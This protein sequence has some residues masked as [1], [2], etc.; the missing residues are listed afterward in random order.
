MKI[1]VIDYGMGNISSVINAISR[2]GYQSKISN[3][4]N[5]ILSSDAIILPGV[6][7]FKEAMQNLKKLNLVEP[8]T[9][10]ANL[11]KKPLLGIC[12]GMQ[13]LAN[14][15]EERGDT[16][17]LSLIPGN[18]IKIPT[19]NNIRLPHIG[20]NNIILNKYC[21]LYKDISNEDS[22]YFVHSY[23]YQCSNEYVSAYVNYG[24]DIVASIQKG[25]IF[26]VQFHPEKSQTKGIRLL[27]NF[28]DYSRDRE[29][30]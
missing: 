25:N 30:I 21:P 26:G 6:G 17:G 15:S 14:T 4:A 19:P 28:L 24:T 16:E 27:K 9:E 22:F 12:L 11:K 7:A 23:F 3:D 1:I 8:L 13:L 29:N 18:V 20:W 5:E 10:F 2:L